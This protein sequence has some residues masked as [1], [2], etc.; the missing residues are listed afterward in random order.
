MGLDRQGSAHGASFGGATHYVTVKCSGLDARPFAKSVR[1]GW[2]GEMA[3]R[4]SAPAKSDAAQAVRLSAPDAVTRRSSAPK[5]ENRGGRGSRSGLVKSKRPQW[6]TVPSWPCSENNA[7]PFNAAIRSFGRAGR[8]CARALKNAE[9]KLPALPK[10][11]PDYLGSAS[12]AAARR[13]GSWWNL[14]G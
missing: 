3:R 10:L 6:Q 8:I 1:A 4:K 11:N 14:I 2:R 5:K 7:A 12:Y 9:F 13:V